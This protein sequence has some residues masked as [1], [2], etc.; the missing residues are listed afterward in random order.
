MKKLFVTAILS[1]LLIV[2]LT[3][4]SSVNNSKNEWKTEVEKIPGVI[5]AVVPEPEDS[6]PAASLSI[7]I[8]GQEKY[9]PEIETQLCEAGAKL[10]EA[11]PITLIVSDGKGA[12]INV[13]TETKCPEISTSYARIWRTVN[14]VLPESQLNIHPD[15]NTY[16]ICENCDIP[17]QQEEVTALLIGIMPELEEPFTFKTKVSASYTPQ[18]P[19]PVTFQGNKKEAVS[20]TTV[21]RYLET[22]IEAPRKITVNNGTMKIS[23]YPSTISQQKLEATQA[24]IQNLV[25][26]LTIETNTDE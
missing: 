8:L 13:F 20:L 5:S 24:E 3:G 6:E 7:T 22:P 17:L 26:T 9:Y 11:T 21:L 16:A 2:G 15:T 25:Q 10:E 23:Y 4:C 18:S 12:K 19:V 1:S 14:Q